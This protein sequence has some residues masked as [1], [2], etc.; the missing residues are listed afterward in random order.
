MD[1]FFERPQYIRHFPSG[2]D[3][4]I[5]T[6]GYDNFNTVKP[7]RV[8]RM[9][10]FYTWHFVLSGV[11]YLEMSGCRFRI[12][13]GQMFFIPPGEKMC[14]YPDDDEPWEYVW[15]SLTGDSALQYGKNVGFSIRE[16]VKYIPIW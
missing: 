3:S 13:K 6:I 2:E 8:F 4:L 9:Q 11:G 12:G 1:A 7:L 16:P 5:K 15:F 10:S 14:Y